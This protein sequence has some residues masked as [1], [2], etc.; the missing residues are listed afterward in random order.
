MPAVVSLVVAGAFLAFMITRFEVDLGDT[1]HRMRAANPWLLASAFLVHY[2]TFIFRGARWRM[3]LQHTAD[4]DESAPGVLYCSQLV[5]L[6]WFAN[7]VGWLRLGDA[8]RAYLYRDERGA[9]F[10]RTIGTILAERALDTVLVLVLLLVSAPFLVR[11][12]D[13]VAWAVFGVAVILAGALAG[14]LVGMR[15]TRA[16]LLR[17]MPLWVGTQ[18][19][20]FHQGTMGSFQRLPLVTLWGLLGWTAEAGRLYLVALA[21]GFDLSWALV[22]FITLA[23]SMLTLV[24][25]PGGVGAV[26][27]GVAGLVVRLGRI[28]SSSAAALVL[29]D[30]SITYLSVIL[31]GAALFLIRYTI[32]QTPQQLSDRSTPQRE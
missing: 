18:Y 31:V 9:S 28:G 17:K 3:L 7:S 5:L 6:G 11:G 30:R 16:F 10:S 20:R 12:G 19:D 14:V 8:Y 29:V 24:P 2:T 22:I 25:T 26:E 32:K 13:N 21:L 27:S 23:N 4:T 15:W 1:W